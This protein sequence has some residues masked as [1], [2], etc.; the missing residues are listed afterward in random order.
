VNRKRPAHAIL[1]LALA[2]CATYTQVRHVRA[3]ANL[4]PAEL[5][6][7]AR[8]VAIM[9]VAPP[10][11]PAGILGRAAANVARNLDPDSADIDLPHAEALDLLEETA[12]S[13]SSPRSRVAA[14]MTASPSATTFVEALGATAVLWLVPSPIRARQ[15]EGEQEIYDRETGRSMIRR[16]MV[17][18]TVFS[19][20]YRL[21][22]WPDRRVLAS[23]S[24][25]DGVKA[26]AGYREGLRSWAI[27]QRPVRQSW[28]AGL[29]ED[30]LP[31]TVWRGRLVHKG[32]SRDLKD[33][34]KAAKHGDWDRACAAWEAGIRAAVANA[35]PGGGERSPVSLARSPTANAGP[36]ASG[37]QSLPIAKAVDGFGTSATD[38]VGAD[39]F[40]TS[41]AGVVD[42]V[43]ADYRL[44]WN[45]GLC[46]EREGRWNEAR[47][48]YAAARDGTTDSDDVRTLETYMAQLDRVYEDATNADMGA[49]PVGAGKWFAE[50]MAVL[51]FANDSNNMGAPDRARRLIFRGLARWGYPVL[52]LEET[53][54][55]MREIGLSDGGQLRAFTPAKLAQ[56]AGANRILTGTVREFKTTNV[57]LYNLHHVAL[58]LRL[59]DETGRVLWESDGVGYR[60]ILFRPADA[61]KAFLGGLIESTVG[62]ATGSDLEEEMETA[63]LTALSSLPARPAAG[64]R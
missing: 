45:L 56:A 5:P 35:G 55:R 53:D 2:G 60:E 31:I 41:G 28:L 52:P 22:S 20:E 21:E 47:E 59:L 38:H 6:R 46:R 37:K 7:L 25:T 36:G 40:G 61:G 34:L 13:L 43:G 15:E 39:G 33:G 44:Q 23:R 12:R 58:N 8:V 64:G 48:L 3:P 4:A 62:K 14:I 42:P 57:G 18:R 63:A 1:A 30:L 10:E 51:P 11:G 19:M 29:R 26:A 16:V 50:Q 9:D 49:G 27:E 32:R 54:R 24:F 17:R